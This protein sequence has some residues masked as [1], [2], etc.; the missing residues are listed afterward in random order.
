MDIQQ[1]P[2]PVC[3]TLRPF[4]ALTTLPDVVRVQPVQII[5]YPRPGDLTLHCSVA[6]EPFI[7]WDD[8]AIVAVVNEDQVI[9]IAPVYTSHGT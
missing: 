4:I 2:R 6:E 8:Q 5:L 9:M 7:E 1:G 3:H